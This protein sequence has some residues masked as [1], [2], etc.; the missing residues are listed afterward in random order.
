VKPDQPPKYKGGR[1]F[2]WPEK[3]FELTNLAYFSSPG[4]FFKLQ[5]NW[6]QPKAGWQPS[7]ATERAKKPRIL[8]MPQ[9]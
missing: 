9:F 3:R 6:P 4:E 2:R 5:L 1:C 8:W 7:Q